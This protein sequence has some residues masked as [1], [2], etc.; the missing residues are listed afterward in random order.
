M[1]RRRPPE[2]MR[3]IAL[4]GLHVILPTPAGRY[5]AIFHVA[6]WYRAQGIVLPEPPFLDALP[7][8]FGIADAAQHYHLP[9]KITP[10][11]FS[12]FRGG[13]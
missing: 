12:V 4:G 9:L 3:P 5:E 7:F 10:W 1:N 2:A 6:A 11:G 8:R 13:V